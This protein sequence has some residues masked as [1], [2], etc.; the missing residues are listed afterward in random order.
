MLKVSASAERWSR[1]SAN[2]GGILLLLSGEGKP[3]S[4][5]VE[6]L[7]SLFCINCLKAAGAIKTS[8]R[9]MRAQ[10]NPGRIRGNQEKISN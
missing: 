1:V 2:H 7:N 5:Q 4:T 9:M 8:K 6:V 10:P 3:I